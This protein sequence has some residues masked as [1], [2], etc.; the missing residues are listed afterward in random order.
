MVFLK[1]KEE[2]LLAIVVDFFNAYFFSSGIS[3]LIFDSVWSNYNYRQKWYS[4]PCYKH[5]IDRSSNWL[6]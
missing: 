2:L 5:Y 6:F 4:V 3:I 1:L